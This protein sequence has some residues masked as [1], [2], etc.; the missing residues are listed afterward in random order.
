M[1]AAHRV[2]FQEAIVHRIE[3]ADLVGFFFV[4]FIPRYDRNPSRRVFRATRKHENARYP[5]N[6]LFRL[7]GESQYIVAWVQHQTICRGYPQIKSWKNFTT[8]EGGASS[9]LYVYN[10]E[11]SL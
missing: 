11:W 3:E 10:A 6:A 8:A 5:S 7:R 9:C 2:C 1:K 4:W